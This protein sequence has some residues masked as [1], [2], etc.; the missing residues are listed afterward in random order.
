VR[1]HSRRGG[2]QD[3]K[4]AAATMRAEVTRELEGL[5]LTAERRAV[6]VTPLPATLH[7]KLHAPLAAHRAMW[8]GAGAS[9]GGGARHGAHA[10][11]AGETRSA[12]RRTETPL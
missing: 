9:D 10:P 6:E 3:R 11:R 2:A 4:R 7:V 1:R 8:L 12:V 5:A